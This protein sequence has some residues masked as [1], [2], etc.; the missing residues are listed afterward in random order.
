[1][2]FK[3]ILLK[4]SG[5]KIFELFSTGSPFNFNDFQNKNGSVTQT[6]LAKIDVIIHNIDKENVNLFVR[7]SFSEHLFLWMNDA[8][9][10]I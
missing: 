4:L 1:M 2:N 8:A 5:D 10:R 9:S 6:L 3:R 7:R